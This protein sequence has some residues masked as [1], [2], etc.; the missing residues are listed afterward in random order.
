MVLGALSCAL[1]VLSCSGDELLLPA[2]GEP[3]ALAVVSG[4]AQTGPVGGQLAAPLVVRVTDTRGRPV[5]GVEVAFSP[6]AGSVN[7]EVANTDAEGLATANWSLGLQTGG[8]E[9]IAQRHIAHSVHFDFAADVHLAEVFQ[10]NNRVIGHATFYLN[11]R[12]K[13]C[14]A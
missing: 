14:N 3:A 7:P 13:V 4:D 10:L 8:Q 6:G 5:A 11:V 2:E 1:V 12:E 9:L